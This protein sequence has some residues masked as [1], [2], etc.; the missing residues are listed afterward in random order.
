[1][2]SLLESTRSILDGAGYAVSA[3]RPDAPL[4]HFED[5]CLLG[6]VR[7]FDDLDEIISSWRQ[8]QELFLRR[9]AASLV[10]D[11]S[12]AWNLYAVFLTRAAVPADM[13]HALLV[14]EEDFRS[15]RKIARG[16][17]RTREELEIVLAP[18]LPI[19]KELRLIPLDV[20]ARL[21]ERLGPEGSPRRLL[22]S[23]APVEDIA[24][25]LME[26]E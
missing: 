4:I 10:Q 5:D 21:L 8:E 14:I 11:P 24:R 20:R 13:A 25:L 7:V 17:I 22:L 1:M 3:A 15:A 9:N 23:D 18:L 26:E 6:F 12:K 19:K 2:I 16:G